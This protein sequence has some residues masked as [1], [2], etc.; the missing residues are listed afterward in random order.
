MATHTTHTGTGTA[1]QRRRLPETVIEDLLDS[2]Q[3]RSLL[4]VLVD[5]DEPVP[6]GDLARE[7]VGT[8]QR[9]GDSAVERRRVR[10]EIYQDHLPKLTATGVVTFDSRL[11]TVE[12]TGPVA[13]RSRVRG[14]STADDDSGTKDK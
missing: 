8:D 1:D 11:G 6:V 13:V 3:R 5:R 10:T 9:D 7:L 2:S 14:P 12:F 4:A